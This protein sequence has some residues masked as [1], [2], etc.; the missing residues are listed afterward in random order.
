M[1]V[2]AAATKRTSARLDDSEALALYR[3]LPA[4]SE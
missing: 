4:L 1:T 3:D 2:S